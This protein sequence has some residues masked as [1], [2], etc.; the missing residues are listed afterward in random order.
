MK[1]WLFQIKKVHIYN[2][3]VPNRFKLD[4]FEN[5]DNF[6]GKKIGLKEEFDNKINF[7]TR[8]DI[9]ILLQGLCMI[10]QYIKMLYN[11][12]TKIIYS[13]IISWYVYR[14]KDNIICVAK[15]RLWL[16]TKTGLL[17]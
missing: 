15:I 11:V 2:F 14:L 5:L 9:F 10:W 13:M 12:N 4:V 3:Q 16:K 17:G 1:I 8:C 6:I 7:I